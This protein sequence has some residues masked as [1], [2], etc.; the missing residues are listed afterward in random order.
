MSDKIKMDRIHAMA[1]V[2]KEQLE[3][4]P[5]LD[6]EYTACA[7]ELFGLIEKID[8]ILADRNLSESDKIM[9]MKKL[10]SLKKVL[11]NRKYIK[12]VVQ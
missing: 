5:D 3:K 6:L 11:S 12:K 9:I 8:L 2:V 4:T 7:K 10:G 1:D